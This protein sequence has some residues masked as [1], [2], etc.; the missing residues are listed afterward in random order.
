MVFTLS[1]QSGMTNTFL[2]RQHWP[3]EPSASYLIAWI[4]G[5]Q[6]F[7]SHIPCSPHDPI[8]ISIPFLQNPALSGRGRTV[9]GYVLPNAAITASP[10]CCT[11]MEH[12]PRPAEVTKKPESGFVKS[13][14]SCLRRARC[15]W[16]WRNQRGQMGCSGRTFREG[17]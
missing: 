9:K 2:C 4:S 8:Y 12:P 1:R 3:A 15:H 6:T 10:C 13:Q 11:H 5:T 14:T 17:G 16:H 7:S